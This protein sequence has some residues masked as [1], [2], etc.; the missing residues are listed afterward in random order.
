MNKLSKHMALALSLA[1]TVTA[2]PATTTS[3]ATKITLKSG[4]AAP[5]TVYAKHSYNLAVKGVKVK[6]YSS[7]KKVATVAASTGKMKAVAPGTVK[8][9]AKNAKG[10][11]VASASFKVLQRATAV[12]ADQTE[13]FLNVNDTAT[14]KATKTPATSTDVVRFYSADKTIATVGAKSGVIT[15]KKNGKVTIKVVSKATAATATSAKSNKVATVTVYVGPCLDTVAQTKVNTLVANFKTDMKDVKA[16]DFSIVNDA[17]KANVLVQEAKA[18]GKK[19]TL[20]T[21]LDLKDGQTYSVTYGDVTAQFTATTGEVADIKL[22]TVTIPAATE[23]EVKMLAVDANG[24]VL[25]E[26]DLENTDPTYSFSV[27]TTSGYTAGKNLF[28]SKKGDTAVASGVY[29]TFKYENGAEVGVKEF[30][31]VVITAVD[32][33]VITTNGFD[34]TIDGSDKAVDFSKLEKKINTIAKG[35]NLY[36]HFNFKNSDGKEIKDGDYANYTIETGNKD[37]LIINGNKLVNKSIKISAVG[38]GSTVLLVKDAQ[39]KNVCSLPITVGP[40]VKMNSFALEAYD[41]TVS[42]VVGDFKEVKVLV[43]DNYNNDVKPTTEQVKIETVSVK[44]YNSTTESD[45]TVNDIYP[46]DFVTY[47]DGKLV[48]ATDKKGDFTFKVTVEGFEGKMITLHAKTPN[49][50]VT[51][52]FAIQ[53]SDTEMDAK[54]T[55][56]DDLNKVI[57]VNVVETKEGLFVD[58]HDEVLEQVKIFKDG[59]EVKGRYSDGEFIV[60]NEE[61]GKAAAGTYTVKLNTTIKSGEKDYKVDRETSFVIKDTQ[62][63]VTAERVKDTV[64]KADKNDKPAILNKSFVFIFDGKSYGAAKDAEALK[65]GNVVVTEMED[66]IFFEKATA[67]IPVGDKELPVEV[68]IGRTITLK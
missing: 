47:E 59:K 61:L 15:A 46:T 63:A 65:F 42:T 33:E 38:E 53:L 16:S 26:V 11:A 64:A 44:A 54:V 13:V 9:T 7:N 28:L 36:A 18:D 56:A 43:K 3:A 4:A 39:G 58:K 19:V 22:N 45:Y 2:I 1:L 25:N 32:Q 68:S 21:Y 6:F 62:G 20:T 40:V 49:E 17:T 31:D 66:S 10:K 48:F 30:K 52:A 24:V 41:T 37:V 5:S 29:H 55:K 35:Q 57:K 51:P 34:Y 12:A 67:Y 23:T 27:K 14:L 50:K 8:I 60:A